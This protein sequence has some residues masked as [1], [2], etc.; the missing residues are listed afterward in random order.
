MKQTANL[1]TRARAEIRFWTTR[2]K[3]RANQK[4]GKHNQRLLRHLRRTGDRNARTTERMALRQRSA[5][6]PIVQLRTGRGELGRLRISI[7]RIRRIYERGGCNIN[8]NSNYTFNQ[9]FDSI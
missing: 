5:V 4:D 2:N 7:F 8:E 3:T 1:E 9:R 6:L